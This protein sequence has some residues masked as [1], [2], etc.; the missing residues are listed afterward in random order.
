MKSVLRP[1]I[2]ESLSKQS[3]KRMGEIIDHIND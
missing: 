1:L 3:Q 2:H